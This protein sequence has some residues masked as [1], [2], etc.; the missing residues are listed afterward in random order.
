MEFQVWWGYTVDYASWECPVCGNYNE[1][2]NEATEEEI[3]Q[4]KNCDFH[5]ENLEDKM[6]DTD[7][8]ENTYFQEEDTEEEN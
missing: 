3:A 5:I 4:C 6:N 7:S 2:T 8:F 1:Y